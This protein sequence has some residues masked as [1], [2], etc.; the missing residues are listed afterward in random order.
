MGGR[1]GEEG[2][3]DNTITVPY[4]ETDVEK[5]WKKENRRH[6][7]FASDV[8]N[9]LTKRSQ[10]GGGCRVYSEST[11]SLST[12]STWAPARGKCTSNTPKALSKTQPSTYLL[13]TNTADTVI[14][15][16]NGSLNEMLVRIK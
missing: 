3:G 13:V 7:F 11:L 15:I 6:I 5:V 14:S 16:T 8:N 4:T 1:D 9:L 12:A 10:Y 2:A